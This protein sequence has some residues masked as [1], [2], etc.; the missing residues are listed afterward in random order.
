[1]SEKYGIAGASD[2]SDRLRNRMNPGDRRGSMAGGSADAGGSMTDAGRGPMVSSPGYHEME[3]RSGNHIT[4]PYAEP[5]Q[6]MR[7]G[8]VPKRPPTSGVSA[9]VP[10][11]YTIV[12]TKT[13]GSSARVRTTTPGKTQEMS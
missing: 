13:L 12:D 5:M 4:L 1:M 3:G 9:I 10:Y 6:V 11:N 8:Q 7:L 2:A